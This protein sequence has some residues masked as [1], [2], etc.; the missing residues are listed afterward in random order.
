MAESL[1]SVAFSSVNF[2][3][4]FGALILILGNRSAISF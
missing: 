4:F 2:I 3:L 1:R